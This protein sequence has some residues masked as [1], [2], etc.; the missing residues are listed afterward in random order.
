MSRFLIGLLS[1][2]I[3]SEEGSGSQTQTLKTLRFAAKTTIIIE[4]T[5]GG[6]LEVVGMDHDDEYDGALEGAV[7]LGTC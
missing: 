6:D 4:D 5:W 2:S 7:D 3:K 1:I